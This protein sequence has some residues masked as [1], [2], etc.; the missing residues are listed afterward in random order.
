M[1]NP[2]L[3]LSICTISSLSNAGFSPIADEDLSTI[4]G[5]AGVTI[6]GDIYATIG[7]VEYTDEGS[8]SVNNIVIGG[9]N[10]QTYFG[11]DWGPGSHSGNKLDGSVIKI[12]V[13]PDGDLVI[14]G[15]VDP[16]VGGIIDFGISTG[17]IQ[18]LSSDKVTTATIVDSISISGVATKFRVKVDAD[19]SH[20]LN[21]A[22]IGIADLDID[23]SGLN[24][25]VENAFI[26]SSS[27]FESVD[28]WGAQGI[29]LSDIV[30]DIRVD[31]YADDEGL[32][33]D[34]QSLEFDMGI[35]SISIADAS[36]GSFKLDNVNFSNASIVVSGHP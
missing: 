29:A 35:G 18:L 13:L 1:K 10:K 17:S 9:A 6:E 15:G 32:H 8:I 23:I 4:S 7:S 26:A 21:Q 24:M 22:E 27:Y 16:A 12:D 20:I 19:T 28:S 30:A 5:Q 25:K 31:I 34:A 36:I 3:I 33:I 11:I 2:F 14:S